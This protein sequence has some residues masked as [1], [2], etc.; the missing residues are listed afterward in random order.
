MAT[1]TMRTAS[2]LA[3]TESL[4]HLSNNLG[5]NDCA[6]GDFRHV[7]ANERLRSVS[8]PKRGAKNTRTRRLCGLIQE[9]LSSRGPRG[10]GRSLLRS[11]LGQQFRD[12]REITGNFADPEPYLTTQGGNCRRNL[13]TCAKNP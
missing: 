11:G 8:D 6:A 4:A 2:P 10:G 12:A 5:N 7:W 9:N 3:I 1:V 13:G